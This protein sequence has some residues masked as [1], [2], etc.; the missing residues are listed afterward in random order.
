MRPA[1]PSADG[2]GGIH[3]RKFI[4]VIVSQPVLVEPATACV[5][6]AHDPEMPVGLRGAGL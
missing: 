4:L 6:A 2:N 1:N 3:L 5:R